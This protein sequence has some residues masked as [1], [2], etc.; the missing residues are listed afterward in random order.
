MAEIEI[1]DLW[2]QVVT[3]AP[4]PMSL[5]EFLRWP[6]DGKRYEL[7]RGRMI[8]M[9][10]TGGG[11][12]YIATK[13]AVALLAQCG[14]LGYAL[15]G[16]TLFVLSLPG[17]EK[18]LVMAPDA[19]FVR[20]ERAPDQDDF[21]AWFAPW[22]V[23]PDLVAEIASPSDR[24]GAMANKARDWLAG[25]VKLVWVLWPMRRR[26]EVW[27]PGDQVPSQVLGMAD[28]LTG[29]DVAPFSLPARDLFIF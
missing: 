21:S 29:G 23:P 12:G 20:K 14:H 3:D 18:P 10:G 5:E 15:T 7:I 9:P 25:G 27:R 24:P 2:G 22:H 17:E 11:H 8:E 26:I 4:Y 19:C 1:A 13:L 6:E 16:D 28:T